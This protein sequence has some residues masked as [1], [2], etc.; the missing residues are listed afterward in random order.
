MSDPARDTDLLD[1]IRRVGA[2]AGTD[3]DAVT[4]AL[5]DGEMTFLARQLTKVATHIATRAG[6]SRGLPPP[7]TLPGAGT[8]RIDL[9]AQWTAIPIAGMFLRNTLTRWLW[10]DVM[11]DADRAVHD[12]TKA[13]VAVIETR[14]LPY[15]TRMTLRLRAASATRLIV[16]LHDSP[17]NAH[18]TTESGNLIS[19]RIENI[20]VRCGQHTNRGRTILWCELARPEYNRWI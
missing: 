4:L 7:G 6:S 8:D 16:E 12:L 10:A 9:S 1:E 11:V 13:F 14:Q 19:P 17:E 15:P 3:L 2:C 5:S 18:I 20:S